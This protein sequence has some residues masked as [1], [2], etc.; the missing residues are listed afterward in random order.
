MEVFNGHY[1]RSF[2]GQNALGDSGEALG[3]HAD[4][5]LRKERG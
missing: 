2:G 5:D 4:K 3:T 1:R